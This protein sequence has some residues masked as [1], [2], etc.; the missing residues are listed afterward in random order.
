M[1]WTTLT[2][3]LAFVTLTTVIMIALLSK[4]RTEQRLDDPDAPES[5]L[6]KDVPSRGKPADV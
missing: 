3:F 4:Y 5:T 2:A 1:D 6:A